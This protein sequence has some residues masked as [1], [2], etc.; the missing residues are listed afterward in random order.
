[1]ETAAQPD[2]VPARIPKASRPMPAGTPHPTATMEPSAWPG[3]DLP[4]LAPVKGFLPHPGQT[5]PANSEPAPVYPQF[6]QC[7]PLKHAPQKGH[8]DD[9]P[10]NT[11]PH[12]PHV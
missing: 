7:T 2:D 9:L 4:G 11:R 8:E 6:L 5:S 3:L 12:M 1:M 10:G